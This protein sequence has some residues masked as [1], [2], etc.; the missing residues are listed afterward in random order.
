MYTQFHDG[1]YAT[2]YQPQGV[3][4]LTARAE[5]SSHY[6]SQNRVV[7]DV[8]RPSLPVQR[9][10]ELQ[11]RI[12]SSIPNSGVEIESIEDRTE[13]FLNITVDKSKVGV[14]LHVDPKEPRLM[15]GIIDMDLD[16]NLTLE[17]QVRI[18]TQT[19]QA[20]LKIM[21]DLDPAINFTANRE[22]ESNILAEFDKGFDN[23]GR[24]LNPGLLKAFLESKR[25]AEDLFAMEQQPY[26]AVHEKM[27]SARH[28]FLDSDAEPNFTGAPFP[29][30]E[31]ARYDLSC[32]GY[33][34]PYESEEATTSF[35]RVL[36]ELG[37]PLE[38]VVRIHYADLVGVRDQGA[39]TLQLLTANPKRA[40]FFKGGDYKNIRVDVGSTHNDISATLQSRV[41][42]GA[43]YDSYAEE[44][45]LDGNADKRG[46]ILETVS[47]TKYGIFAASEGYY[48]GRMVT[49]GGGRVSY[50]GIQ[51]Q[52]YF[53]DPELSKDFEARYD[54]KLLS[55]SER[56]QEL[57]EKNI[58][59]RMLNQGIEIMFS[60]ELGRQPTVA[61]L[62]RA[63][64]E[65][66]A[67]IF[68][69]LKNKEKE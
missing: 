48:V 51:N 46:M 60:K 20:F 44:S 10:A 35:S 37:L 33:L 27:E 68:K 19:G 17:E 11:N 52:L 9:L 42:E 28:K 32:Q 43:Q 23:A 2:H 55:S 4:S 26:G 39:V 18:F 54:L 41:S 29:Y 22:A 49:R 8:V 3:M 25:R 59:D 53:A 13:L 36:S 6:S 45:M 69:G 15:M 57:F 24:L 56:A 61:E 5:S 65:I 30:E 58:L 67:G 40:E 64:L 50:S 63:R 62:L 34:T 21:N 47:G 14:I 38:R 31:V 7:N 1:S 12:A 16:P 66:Q